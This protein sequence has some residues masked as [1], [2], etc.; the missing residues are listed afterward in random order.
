MFEMMCKGMDDG[1][2]Q[3]SMGKMMHCTMGKMAEAEKAKDPEMDRKKMWD[4]M[5]KCHPRDEKKE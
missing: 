4:K 1:T 3:K 5:K 2:E